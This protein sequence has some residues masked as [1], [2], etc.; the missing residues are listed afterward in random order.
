[1]NVTTPT[2]VKIHQEYD[3]ITARQAIRNLAEA[4]GF[5]GCDLIIIATAVSELARNFLSYA[6]QGELILS[7]LQEPSG[8]K[9]V[10]IIA[11]DQGPGIENIEDAMRDGFSTGNSLGLG[12]PGAKRLMDEFQITSAVGQGT[13]VT[14]KKWATSNTR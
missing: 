12:L 10:Q 14:V 6:K 2:R 8:R 3:I 1:V 4:A 7:L 9:G 13:Q 11:Q 5:A